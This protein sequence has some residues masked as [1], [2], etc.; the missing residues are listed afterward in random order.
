MFCEHCGIKIEEGA[1]FCQSC[2]KSTADTSHAVATNPA[3]ATASTSE[4]IIKC[5][6]C[7][8][9]G[10]GEKAR[11]IAGQIL[12]WLCF[13]WITLIYYG[14]THKYRCPKCKSTFLGIK[15]KD[16]VFVND[17]KGGPLMILVYVMVGIF[18]LGILSSVIL[19]S[20]NSAR[21]KAKQATEQSM[22][23]LNTR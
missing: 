18:I 5:G 13:P 8:Y 7:D 2:G 15:N 6:S 10:P 22:G 16:G 19:A 3:G 14:I 11:S 9:I 17:K 4:A 21:E 23:S 1:Q 12:A 20:L